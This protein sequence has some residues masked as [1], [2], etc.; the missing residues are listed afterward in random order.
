MARGPLLDPRPW[1]WHPTL[2]P[3]LYLPGLVPNLYLPILAPNLRLPALAPNLYLSVQ[4]KILLLLSQLLVLS[5]P[6]PLPSPP[7]LLLLIIIRRTRDAFTVAKSSLYGSY[8]VFDEKV[9]SCFRKFV[10]VIAYVSLKREAA[11][12]IVKEID[13]WLFLK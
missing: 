6:L 11:V 10:S 2:T 4:V 5:L 1:P 3:N 13:G 7:P 12:A 8:K 9:K